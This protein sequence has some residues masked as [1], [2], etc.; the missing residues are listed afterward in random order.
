[1]ACS[2]TPGTGVRF[3]GAIPNA[4]TPAHA[5][6]PAAG[7]AN[8]PA[9]ITPVASPLVM[10]RDIKIRVAGRVVTV[11]FEDYVAGTALSEISPTGETTTTVERV[12]DIQTIVARTYALAHIGRHRAD[13]FDLCDSTHCQLYEP[14]RLATS[15]FAPD[16]RRSV[17]RTAGM[18][19]TYAGRPI[20]ALFHADCGG[21]T[22][23][24]EQVWGTAPLPYLRSEVDPAPASTHR[25]WTVTLAREQ[26]RIALNG[27]AR[28]SVGGRLTSVTA[29]QIDDS[30]RVT[31]VRVSGD[32]R[33]DIRG[34]E[35]RAVVNRALRTQ[36]VLSTRFSIRAEGGSLVLTGTGNGHGIGLCQ[37]GAMARARRGIEPAAILTGYFPGTAIA[38]LR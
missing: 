14:Q 34:D 37:V 3:P 6:T 36:S 18:V 23:T 35:F 5:P 30:G 4:A 27:D 26:L 25:E 31:D 16:A 38:R 21:H 10:P 11:A 17:A 1:M 22:A 8:P 33:V 32:R 20:D 9:A 19:L 7:A 28:T 13:G 2:G 29:D 15:R 12:F 24:P